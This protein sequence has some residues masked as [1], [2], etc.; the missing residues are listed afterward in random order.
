M[1]PLGPVWGVS[2]QTSHPCHQCKVRDPMA[3][4]PQGNGPP[5]RT[6]LFL[7]LYHSNLSAFPNLSADKLSTSEHHGRACHSDGF[8]HSPGVAPK[9]YFLTAVFSE[10]ANSPTLTYHL[11]WKRGQVPP[12]WPHPPC[13]RSPP[14][15][16]PSLSVFPPF[17]RAWSGGSQRMHLKTILGLSSGHKEL[18]DLGQMIASLLASSELHIR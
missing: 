4:C 15:S 9:W 13:C 14:S 11:G 3:S 18:Y 8:W 2:S 6:L 16:K 17:L 12:S 5:H 7:S 1:C 10:T